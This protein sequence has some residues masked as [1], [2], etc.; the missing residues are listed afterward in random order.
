M[1]GPSEFRQPTRSEDDAFYDS[2][3][4]ENDPDAHRTPALS[5][6]LGPDELPVA[7]AAAAYTDPAVATYLGLLQQA[8]NDGFR[9]M[10]VEHGYNLRAALRGN[11]TVGSDERVSHRLAKYAVDS[12]ERAK[13]HRDAGGQ[14]TGFAGKSQG[15]LWAYLLAT[16]GELRDTAIAL[17]HAYKT[18][19]PDAVKSEIHAV[20]KEILFSVGIGK[21]VAES[22][23]RVEIGRVRAAMAANT[24]PARSTTWAG[25][26][27]FDK[28]WGAGR[29]GSGGN[30]AGER[31][32]GR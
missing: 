5:A 26:N 9:D 14:G 20:A 7:A 29:E 1:A 10:V 2:Q 19:Q 6:T 12:A 28:R 13:A 11:D 32:G 18:N 16:N 21:S 17:A 27:E 24:K 23:L 8:V 22:L 3:H 30:E 4:P 31:W 25:G 15:E